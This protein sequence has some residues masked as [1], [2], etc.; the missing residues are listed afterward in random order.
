MG[1]SLLLRRGALVIVR[2][3]PKPLET[4]SC[5]VKIALLFPP[6][7]PATSKAEEDIKQKGLHPDIITR[8][9]LWKNCCSGLLS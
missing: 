5:W 7:H 2:M 9:Y 3:K 8:C 6:F 1:G 4:E